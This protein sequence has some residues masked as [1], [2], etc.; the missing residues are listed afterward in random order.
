MA[1]ET[2]Q[3]S[4]TRKAI[5]KEGRD[6]TWTRW[7][8]FPLVT[9]GQPLTEFAT[10]SCDDKGTPRVE[11]FILFLG[12]LLNSISSDINDFMLKLP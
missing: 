8:Y 6:T 5:L 3:N 12:K 7:E 2:C 9:A 4:G 1:R 10:L 11:M